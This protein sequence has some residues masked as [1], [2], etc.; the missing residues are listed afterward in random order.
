MYAPHL[1]SSYA[2]RY[3]VIGAVFVMISA[4]FGF[5]VLVVA[6]AALAREVTDELGPDP[7]WRATARRR[8]PAR[9]GRRHR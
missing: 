2:T 5:M 4:L 8:G 7:R 6:S 9:V 1:F 3:G